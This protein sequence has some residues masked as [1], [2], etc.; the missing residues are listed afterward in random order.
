MN[1]S[2]RTVCR[3]LERMAGDTVVVA[4]VMRDV[5]GETCPLQVHGGCVG[6]LAEVR[7]IDSSHV[8]VQSELLG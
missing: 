4:A 8:T 6:R 5:L 7:R 3:S 2:G 1:R